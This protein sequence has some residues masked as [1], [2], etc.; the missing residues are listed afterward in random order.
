MEYNVV[1]LMLD[2]FATF[3]TLVPF[4][5]IAFLLCRTGKMVEKNSEYVEI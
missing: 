2:D 5:A 3:Q 4:S 1:A